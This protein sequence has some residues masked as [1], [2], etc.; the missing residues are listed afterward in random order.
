[1]P[2][3]L[4][5][6]KGQ[7]NCF[8]KWLCR[9]PLIRHSAKPMRHLAKSVVPGL[10]PAVS[11]HTHARHTL[12][13]PTHAH[14]AAAD[15]RRWP[16]APRR[17]RRAHGPPPPPTRA[18]PGPRPRCRPEPRRRR[19]CPGVPAPPRPHR[20][21]PPGRRRRWSMPPR[22]GLPLIAAWGHAGLRR[23]CRGSALPAA[24]PRREGNFS[25]YF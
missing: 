12:D 22:A 19:P 1:M 14:A 3:D 23:C 24:P 10:N 17:R 8:L 13:T 11:T 18:A 5:L 4:A 21:A 9:V 20:P 25:K 2:A 7:I 16:S 6:G 15:P